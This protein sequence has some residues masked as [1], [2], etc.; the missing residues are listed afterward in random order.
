MNDRLIGIG[1]LLWMIAIT[2]CCMGYV[3][4]FAPL[5]LAI[6]GVTLALDDSVSRDRMGYVIAV[7]ITGGAIWFG[8]QQQHRRLESVAYLAHRQTIGCREADRWETFGH[9][10][11]FPEAKPSASELE[12]C[13]QIDDAE[14]FRVYLNARGWP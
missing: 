1:G 2:I 7:M 10:P 14:D 4:L 9:D 3:Q 6:L 8:M 11:N 13:R 5:S 12:R